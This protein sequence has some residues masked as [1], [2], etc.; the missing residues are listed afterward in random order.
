MVDC[1]VYWYDQYTGVSELW[2]RLGLSGRTR[3]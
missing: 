3:G 1:S 2:T